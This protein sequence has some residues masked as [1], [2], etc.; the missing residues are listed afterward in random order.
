MGRTSSLLCF[1]FRGNKAEIS[2]REQIKSRI[3]E[4]S[5]GEKNE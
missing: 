2:N 3:E 1:L 4:K 5:E